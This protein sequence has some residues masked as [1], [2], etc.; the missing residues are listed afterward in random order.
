MKTFFFIYISIGFLF[1]MFLKTQVDNI[2]IDT[3]KKYID[4]EQLDKIDLN[5][6]KTHFLF[7]VICILL[8]PIII[9]GSYN[10]FDDFTKMKF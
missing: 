10:D 5:N 9:F 1:C 7:V 3:I 8:W 4:N 6:P 2:G